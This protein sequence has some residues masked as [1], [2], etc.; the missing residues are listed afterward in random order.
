MRNLCWNIS[1]DVSINANRLIALL[2][3]ATVLSDLV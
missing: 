2:L 3:A 1:W